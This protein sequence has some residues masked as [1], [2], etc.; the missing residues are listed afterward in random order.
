MKRA[1]SSIHDEIRINAVNGKY[2]A[3]KAHHKAYVRR[4]YSKFQGMKIVANNELRNKVEDWLMNGQSPEAISGRIKK[5]E[6]NLLDVSKNSIRRFIKSTYGRK[7]EYERNKRKKKRRR[8]PKRPKIKNKRSIHQ[9]PVSIEKRR[10]VGDAE[11]DFIVSGKSGKGVI[12]TL[13]DRRLRHKFLERILHPDFAS[14][15]RAGSRIKKRYSEWK[16]MTTDNDFL[17]A[18]HKQLEKDWGVLIF[19]CDEHAP[20]QK[21]SIENANKEIRLDIPK[22]SDISKFSAYKI[23]KLEIRLNNKFMKCL[24]YRSP[25]EALILYRKRKNAL[26]R[27]SKNKRNNLSD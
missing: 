4:K 20:W 15:R 25:H 12:F 16:S 11:G 23:K 6:R 7:I 8:H 21:G 22:S 18:N 14:V 3:E 5:R 13:I 19:F 1:Y 17:F 2:D 10:N 24:R 27:A 26:A 9:R